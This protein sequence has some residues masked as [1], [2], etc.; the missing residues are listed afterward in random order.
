MWLRRPD[1]SMAMVC[2]LRRDVCV[3]ALKASLM[4]NC[5]TR[6]VLSGCFVVASLAA[7]LNALAPAAAAS[8]FTWRDSNGVQQFS[9]RCPDGENCSEKRV[10]GSR[11]ALRIPTAVRSFWNDA[12]RISPVRLA[13]TG[14]RPHDAD[15]ASDSNQNAAGD[16]VRPGSGMGSGFNVGN[17]PGDG[18][19]L[20][21]SWSGLTDP[22]PAGYRVYY[23]RAGSTFPVPGQ[24][25]DVGKAMTFVLRSAA[26]GARYTFKI[27]AYD[28]AGNE[29]VFSNV[30]YKTVP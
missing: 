20:L 10:A 23:A 3:P 11:S 14:T 18:V 15:E 28:N 27:S 24:G 2:K 1:F 12:V 6:S 30:F 8:M 22:P 7:N 16:S 25:I 9:D 19:G 26:S 29:I 17:G 5:L 13:N 21:L 4:S